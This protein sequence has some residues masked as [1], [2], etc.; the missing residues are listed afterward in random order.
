M[1]LGAGADIAPKA[2]FDLKYKG[3]E[4]TMCHISPEPCLTLIDG[5]VRQVQQQPFIHRHGQ[6]V[7]TGKL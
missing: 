5:K 1:G 3:E 6:P 4:S 7:Y 2:I